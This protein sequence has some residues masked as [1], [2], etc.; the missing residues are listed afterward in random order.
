MKMP[1]SYNN[2]NARN[3]LR[4]KLHYQIG[5]TQSFGRA[6]KIEIVRGCVTLDFG[7]GHDLGW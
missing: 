1:V 6:A 5:Y 7:S 3:P 2:L 4:V